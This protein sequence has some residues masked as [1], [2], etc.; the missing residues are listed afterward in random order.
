[1]LYTFSIPI[2]DYRTFLKQDTHKLDIAQFPR[3]WNDNSFLR[4]FGRF[5]ARTRVTS[6]IPYTEKKYAKANNGIHFV[7]QN[8]I[9]YGCADIVPSCVFR[10][11]FFDAYSA[12]LDIGIKNV[13]RHYRVAYGCLNVDDVINTSKAL[14]NATIYSTPFSN[15]PVPL[16]KIGKDLVAEY[17]YATTLNPRSNTP[18]DMNQMASARCPIVVVELDECELEQTN[19][20][21]SKGFTEYRRIP[22]EWGIRLGYRISTRN[23]PLF[24]LIRNKNS[25]KEKLRALRI[26]LLK[27]HQERETLEAIM[28]LIA[29]QNRELEN[30]DILALTS[31]LDDIT[32]V[33]SR[34]RRDGINQSTVFGIMRGIE[35]EVNHDEC[36]EML[37]LLFKDRRLT[38]L[39]RRFQKTIENLYGLIIK[40]DGGVVVKKPVKTLFVSYKSDD[41]PIADLI[42]SRIE[43]KVGSEVCISRYT[44]LEYKQSFREFMNSIEDH[45]FVM[46]IVSD[47]YLKSAACMYEVGEV[48]KNH[49][50]TEKLLHIILGSED[51][52]YYS[53]QSKFAPA[54][55]FNATSRLQYTVYWKDECEKLREAIR[56]I[57]DVSATAKAAQ[58]LREYEQIYRK[59]IEDFTT[60]LSRYNAKTLTKHIS[61]DFDDIINGMKL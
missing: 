61:N 43:A 22:Q 8:R 16:Y 36:A 3:N 50:Y 33:Y 54:D 15:Q 20:L 38:Y 5:G 41:E 44:E 47:K 1:M 18:Y 30:I 13:S 31:Y 32:S 27:Q 21:N 46:C 45:D 28:Q 49:H 56:N 14:I 26:N 35:S 55:V 51:A 19:I 37:M 40:E 42:I 4:N 39:A 52:K 24:V 17:I 23:I 10:R 60:F 2:V 59:D 58:T 12:R 57:D 48:I 25:D 6:D 34:S 53:D 29:R 7:N 11:M 9:K